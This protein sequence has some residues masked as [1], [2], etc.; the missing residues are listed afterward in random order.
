MIHP[1]I[2]HE[3]IA[4]TTLWSCVNFSLEQV[5]TAGKTQRSLTSCQGLEHLYFF[6]EYLL[7]LAT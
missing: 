5:L 7:S 1:S 2:L 4:Y 6:L 3:F